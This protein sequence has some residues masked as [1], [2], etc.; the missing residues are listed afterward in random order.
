MYDFLADSTER[1]DVLAP[2]F[3]KLD[4]LVGRFFVPAKLEL[5]LHLAKQG[6]IPTPLHPP[7]F[8]TASIGALIQSVDPM[9]G[10]GV[11]NGD[12]PLVVVQGGAK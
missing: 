11:P 9:Y 5:V 4:E 12:R 3:I 1:I 10:L 8:A 6:V 2:M 7:E